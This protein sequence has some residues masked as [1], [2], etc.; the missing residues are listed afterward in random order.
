MR[1]TRRA[2]ESLS[3]NGAGYEEC[4]KHIAFGE[5][6]DLGPRRR[7]FA[8]GK[9]ASR[10]EEAGK[11]RSR[12]GRSARQ[13]CGAVQDRRKWRRTWNFKLLVAPRARRLRRHG[14][15]HVGA[16][17]EGRPPHHLARARERAEELHRGGRLRSAQ[18]QD[19]RARPTCRRATCAP[20]RWRPAATSWRS[21]I[22][23]RRRAEAGR[24]R[25][26]RHFQSGE[27]ALDLVLR[28]LRRRIRAACTSSGSATAN[29]STW[30]RARRTS[31]RPIRRTTSS[32]AHR[33]AQ[34]VEAGRGRPLADAGHQAGR[35]R[36][37][38]AAPS[39]R[40]G[41]SRAQQQRLSAAAG[42]LLS[43]LYR[44]RHAHPGH[45][46]QVATRSRSRPGPTRRPTPASCT[47]WC[48]C[49]TAG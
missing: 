4:E 2:A 32:T 6:G 29:T 5:T 40:Q 27:A 44:R 24:L 42:P 21:P 31:S 41:L 15:G 3:G 20:T 18:A 12:R 43:R 25:A 13:R 39:A 48:R 23:P 45:L 35:Q 16:D 34:S 38:A 9:A 30:R 22:R 14:R 10:E 7:S 33:R 19:G 47:P 11:A 8:A 37:A 17:R 1:R 46:R 26:V 49:S 28:L 36:D